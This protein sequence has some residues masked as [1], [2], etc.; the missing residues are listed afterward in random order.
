MH[1][2]CQDEGA[3]G[4]TKG[5]LS[6]H[7]T[8]NFNPKYGIQ[9]YRYIYLILIHKSPNSHNILESFLIISWMH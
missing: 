2:D 3:L 5:A 8:G 6:L 4:S 9:N 1:A 7:T